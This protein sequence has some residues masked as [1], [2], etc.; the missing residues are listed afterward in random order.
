M[1]FTIVPVTYREACA[2]I[3]A[4]H[5]HHRPPR[6]MKFAIGV[7]EGD[8]LVGVVTAGRP[9]ARQLDDGRTI[10]VTRVCT[11]GRRNAN[12]ALY[13]AAWR[14]GRA[15]GYRRLI[16]YTQAGECGASQRAAGLVAVAVLRPRS[17]WCTPTRP[18]T[19]HGVDDVERIRWEVR[20]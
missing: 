11:N 7:A 4:H 20:A 19:G 18:R 5:R 3:D 9:V 6:G 12:S 10:E 14:V 8:R 2:F 15:M 1:G 16:T 13:G 17:G